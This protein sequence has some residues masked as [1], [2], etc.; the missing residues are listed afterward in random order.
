MIAFDFTALLG[1]ITFFASAVLQNMALGIVGTLVLVGAIAIRFWVG[2]LED[3]AQAEAEAT[4]RLADAGGL[5]NETETAPQPAP[6]AEMTPSMATLVGEWF[7][8]TGER[9]EIAAQRLAL[10]IA[11][12]KANL[13]VVQLE[14]EL[15]TR[16]GGWTL[17]VGDG[18][19]VVIGQPGCR[20]ADQVRVT[21]A[22]LSAIRA[23]RQDGGVW[24]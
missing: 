21:D 13:R 6:P 19:A 7:V 11:H 18:R 1:A 20:L 24:E 15:M 22:T 14:Q 17:H 10:G 8:R 12:G 2:A 16:Y 23:A 9:K 5:W 3:R 4:E